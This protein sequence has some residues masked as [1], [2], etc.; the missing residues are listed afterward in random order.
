M[1]L[2]MN[3]MVENQRAYLLSCWLPSGT[4]RLAPK[5]NQINPYFTNLALIALVRLKEWEAVRSHIEWYLHHVNAD[6]YV[7]DYRLDGTLEVDTGKAD[8]EDSYHT[9]LFSLLAEFVREGGETDWIVPH[10]D[11]LVVLMQAVG[12]LQQKDGLTWAKRS[13]RVKYLMDNCEVARGFED[14]AYL[15]AMLGDDASAEEARKRA[16]A[17]RAGIHS[18]YSGMRKSYAVYDSRYPGWRKWYPDVTS[19][20]FPILYQMTRP[21]ED[22]MLYEKITQAFPHFDT[23]QTGDLYPWMSMGECARLMG[24]WRRVDSMLNTANELYIFG[25]RSQY[26]LIHESGRYVEL[27]LLCQ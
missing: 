2:A 23:F 14:A 21:D 15:F 19:Q 26:W 7:N 4:F 17:C 1:V 24:D 25:P 5:N 13:Y 11:E 12:K 6:G 8:S 22:A 10:K 27:S 9:T 20:A 18:M 3:E 16:A